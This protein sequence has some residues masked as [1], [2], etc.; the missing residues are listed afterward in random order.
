[1]STTIN[2]S[3]PSITFTDGTTQSTA[4]NITAPYTSNGVV[5]ASSTT[6]LATGSALTF[7]GT[8]LGLGATPSAF[9]FPFTSGTL[10]MAGGFSMAPWSS[11]AQMY[12]STNAYYN[13][14]WKY[15]ASSKQAAQYFLGDGG[16]S[17]YISP[18][19]T[20][21][22]AITFTQA[23]TLDSNGNLCINRT[24]PTALV[25]IAANLATQNGI[26]IQ[27]TGTTYGTGSTYAIFTNSTG[28]LAGSIQ[29]TAALVTVYNTVSDERLKENIVASP[30]ALDKVLQIPVKS[31][32]WKEDSHH[33]EFGFV[34]QELNAIYPEAVSVGGDD[35]KDNPWGIEYGRLTPILVKAI[36]ELKAINDT[37]VA[38]ITALK[39]KVG[40]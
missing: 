34:A 18:S 28:G 6:A 38:D 13:S 39:A 14:G 10:Q 37:Q 5:Y 17:W 16:H 22:N 3:S 15:N 24:T 20:A 9:T 26:A 4:A 30:M 7:D 27:D 33:V 8:N 12:I 23:M 1:M 40:I 21:G 25:G 31:Y 32:D 36:Q 29:H 19:G 35:E 2:G 11:N